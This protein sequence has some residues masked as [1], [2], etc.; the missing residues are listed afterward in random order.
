[1]SLTLC[2]SRWFV[3]FFFFLENRINMQYIERWFTVFC[4]H[5]IVRNRDRSFRALLNDIVNQKYPKNVL[6]N[7]QFIN[8]IFFFFFYF[9]FALTVDGLHPIVKLTMTNSLHD[10]V[11]TWYLFWIQCVCQFILFKWIMKKYCHFKSSNQRVDIREWRI[12]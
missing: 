11:I 12:H 9:L 10:A 2:D 8:F 5:Y 4:I 1:M 6:F 3:W 7:S